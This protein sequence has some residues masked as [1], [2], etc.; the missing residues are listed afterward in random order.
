[1]NGGG[2]RAGA[3]PVLSSVQHAVR[4]T[5]RQRILPRHTV[6]TPNRPLQARNPPEKRSLWKDTRG[7]QDMASAGVVSNPRLSIRQTR[8]APSAISDRLMSRRKQTIASRSWLAETGRLRSIASVECGHSRS[9]GTLMTERP[10]RPATLLRVST[11]P[12]AGAVSQGSR[13]RPALPVE[14][15]TPA[16]RGSTSPQE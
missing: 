5:P 10:H 6:Y 12:P 7:R 2:D 8:G 13:A 16:S 9:V 1:M 3:C 11:R 15:A 14:Q 4:T